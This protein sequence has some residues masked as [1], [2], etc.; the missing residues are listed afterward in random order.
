MKTRATYNSFYKNGIKSLK[1]KGTFEGN[2]IKFEGSELLRDFGNEKV[3][4][5]MAD[6]M[7][8]RIENLPSTRKMIKLN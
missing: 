3:L 8:N 1:K 6:I 4:K 7:P 2:C 5:E